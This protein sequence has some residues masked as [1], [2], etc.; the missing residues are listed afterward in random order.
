MNKREF[1]KGLLATDKFTQRQVRK[2][3]QGPGEPSRLPPFANERINMSKTEKRRN[4]MRAAVKALQEF[5]ATYDQQPCYED[6]GDVTLIDDALYA[7]GIALD[8]EGYK[9]ANGYQKFKDEIL[10]PHLKPNAVFSGA[11]TEVEK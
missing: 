11:G 1:L 10:K 6:Y 8:P 3:S 2:D 5:W 9:F 4:R 7:I